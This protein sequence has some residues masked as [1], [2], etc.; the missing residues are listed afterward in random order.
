MYSKS[1]TLI[2]MTFAVASQA[3]AQREFVRSWD[4]GQL[5]KEGRSS[6]VILDGGKMTLE[7][8]ILIEDDSPG[9]GY[10]SNPASVEILRDGIVLKKTLILDRFPVRGASVVAMFY[11]DNPAQP[12]N[13]RHVVFTVNGTDFPCEIKH[14]WTHAS[15]PANV[16]KKGENEIL[17]RTLESDTRF[18]T[19]IALEENFRIGSLTRTHRP[20]RSAR[21]TD[22]GKIWDDRHL[23]VNASVDGEYPIRLALDAYQPEGWVE[24]PIIDLA[25]NA[26]QD[27]LQ[28]PVQIKEVAVDIEM[29]LPA[30]TSV[31]LET[32]SGSGLLPEAGG[33]AEWKATGGVMQGSELKGRYVQFR[34]VCKS[35]RPDASPAILG[36]RIRSKYTVSPATDLSE[37]RSVVSTHY[38][39]I[40][41]SFP[42]EYENPHFPRL[43]QF[44]SRM[45]LDS[46]VGDARTEFEKM[47]RIK[48]WVAKQWNW[49]LLKPEQD[50][51]SWDAGKIMTP[52]PGGKVEGGFC[53]HYAIVLM[54]ALQS[55][56]FPARI[57]SVDY[58]V[59]GGHEVVEVWSN[60]FGKWIFLDANFDTYFADQATGVPMNVLE[61]HDFLLRYYFAGRV[62]NRDSWSREDLAGMARDAGKPSGVIGVLGGNANSGTLKS[63]EWWNPPVEQTPYCGGYGP[64]VMGYL[65]YMPRSNYLSKPKPIPVNHGRT[66]W[67]WNGYYCW[68]DQQTPRSLEHSTFTNRPSDLYWNLNQIDFRAV[69]VENGILKI[70][71]VSNT[72]DLKEY[73]LTVNGNLLRTKSSSFEVRL[74][75]GL[76]RIEMRVTDTMGNRGAASMLE[77]AF[78]PKGE[79]N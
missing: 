13:G 7:N 77:C 40:R 39:V 53:L 50:I 72:P 56:G 17:V 78:I 22:G 11:P 65:R 45:K 12:N 75:R 10:S 73:E 69:V 21:S 70:A 66:H 71:M 43:R 14:F 54:Q 5:F 63:Y 59:W 24:S 36:A 8:H 52:G 68:Y 38:T 35:S 79:E 27:V 9:C 31:D 67:G 42:F 25:E 48:G 15:V 47:L 64:L 34:L 33:W 2:F 32:R 62:I 61:M 44:H 28:L 26:N 6:A 46:V 30:E 57:V 23:G 29:E 74:E 37:F 55:F 51:N 20:N 1:L 58:S 49:H 16:L 60:Q 18:K 76:N 4:P 3:F 41:S 19:W